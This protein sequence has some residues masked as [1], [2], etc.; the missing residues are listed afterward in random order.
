MKKM[1]ITGA[2]RGIGKAT[3]EKFLAEG[4]E[5]VGTS[6]SGSGWQHKGLAWLALDLTN[7]ESIEHAATEAAAHAPYDVLLNNS[8]INA[9]EEDIENSPVIMTALRRTLEV[10]LIGTIDFCERMLPHLRDGAHV[11]SIGSGWGTLTDSRSSAAPSYSISKAGLSMYTIRLANRLAVRGVK[12]SMINPGWVLTDMGGSEAP[13]KPEEPAAEI[14]EL[15][16]SD[17]PSGKFWRQ[18]KVQEW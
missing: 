9:E 12:A 5:V 18:G 1:I 11:I 17:V 15:A 4:W 2:S 10:N 13:R 16:T 3:A 8:G 7:P 14:Y 6:T